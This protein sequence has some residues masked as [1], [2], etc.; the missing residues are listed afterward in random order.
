MSLSEY[1]GDEATKWATLEAL[2]TKVFRA[3]QAYLFVDPTMGTP[4]DRSGDSEVEP[5]R[6]ITL[7]LRAFQ[8]PSQLC[9][10]L[11]PLRNAI[12]GF[13]DHSFE[14]AWVQCAKPHLP[15]PICGWINS[16]LSV[17][18]LRAHLVSQMT[19]REDGKP[20]LLRFYDPRVAQHM[21]AFVDRGFHLEGLSNW[22][23]LGSTGHLR[24]LPVGDIGML[25]ELPKD[26]ITRLDWLRVINHVSADWLIHTGGGAVENDRLYDAV[27]AAAEAGLSPLQEADCIAFILHRC[28]VH[29][30]I[31][32]H[33]IVAVWLAEAR[34]GRCHY[35]DA[36][37]CA[38]PEVWN[39]IAA[40]QWLLK[41]NQ[42]QGT[43]HG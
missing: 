29:S 42:K 31:E 20:W 1:A 41:S 21:T 26:A 2:R 37:A 25:S 19:R 4:W 33:P 28:L 43:S 12:G 17:N 34:S 40:G 8:F 38:T 5:Y 32:Q 6:E 27:R 18:E 14:Q 13:F 10:F 16:D 15:Y 7:E 3:G 23:F 39:E 36:A 35:V 24:T 30:Q 11:V 22:W 9:P